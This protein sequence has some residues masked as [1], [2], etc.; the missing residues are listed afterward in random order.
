MVRRGCVMEEEGEP[1]RNRKSVRWNYTG[2]D[3]ITYWVIALSNEWRMNKVMEGNKQLNTITQEN[4]IKH[5]NTKN[6]YNGVVN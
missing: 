4:G 5:T 6:I 3:D 2:N 1:L